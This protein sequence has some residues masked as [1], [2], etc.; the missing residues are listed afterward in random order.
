MINLDGIGLAGSLLHVM[1]VLA[2]VGSALFIFLYLWSK[3]RLDMDQEPA[4][5][6]FDGD[7][8]P[9]GRNDNK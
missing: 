2:F 4:E 9:G 7:K 1:I 5:K 8:K 3:G 6:M